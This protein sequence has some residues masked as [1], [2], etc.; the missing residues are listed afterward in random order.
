MGKR[1]L[2]NQLS[3]SDL[4]GDL[5]FVSW[6]GDLTWPSMMN[7]EP[8]DYTPPAPKTVDKVEISDVKD[9]FVDYILNDKLGII[10]S[11]HLAHADSEGVDSQKCLIL[12]QLASLAVDFA[13]TG[14][15]AEWNP[16]LKVNE[17][18]DFMDRKGKKSYKSE[19]VLGRLYRKI[20]D[21]VRLENYSNVVYNGLFEFPGYEEFLEEAKSLKISYNRE[22]CAIMNQFGIKFESEVLSGCILKSFSKKGDETRQKVRSAVRHLRKKYRRI[23]DDS[24]DVQA[25]ASA[26][27]HVCYHRKYLDSQVKDRLL[28]FAWIAHDHLVQI[29]KLRMDDVF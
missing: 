2:P 14:V 19:K 23:L 5:Y 8:M 9:F 27:Y 10:S 18:P 6:D 12:A 21:K 7:H 11:A 24:S 16:D 26:W 17:Y 28:S 22:L 4:D 15:P 25:F 1:P 20:G 29:Q 13:K 3:G